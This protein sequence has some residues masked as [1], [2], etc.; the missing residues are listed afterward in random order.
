MKLSA[1]RTA[2]SATRRAGTLVANHERRPGTT[3]APQMQTKGTH[4]TSD[5]IGP[6]WVDGQD[7]MDRM[8][9]PFG[10][11]LLEAAE[12]EGGHVVLDVGCGT[13][14]TTLAAWQ[15]VAP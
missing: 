7:R 10:Q 9:A 2:R 4:W 5:D 15:R 11:R 13:G 8:L 12:L 3:R 6:E 1:A 14:S